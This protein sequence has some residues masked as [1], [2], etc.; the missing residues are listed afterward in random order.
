MV[1]VAIVEAKPSRNNYQEY[2]GFPFDQYQLCSNPSI[3]K[4][5]KRDVDI[6]IDTDEYDFVILVG[7]EPLK[8]FTKATSITDYSGSILEKK[9]LPVINPAMLTFKPEVRSLWESSVEKV[10]KYIEGD[11]EEFNPFHDG[12]I[13]IEEPEVAEAYLEMI[14]DLEPTYVGLDSET[15]GLYPRNGY[16]LGMSIS[17]IDD[18]G[19]YICLQNAYSEKLVELLQQVADKH[20][21][22]FHNSKFDIPFFSYHLG[23]KFPRYEDTM[24]LHYL[25]D[26]NPGTHGLKQ[27]AMRYTRY[28]DY[29]KTMYQ[30][31]ADYCKTHGLRRA[32][33]RWEFIPFDVMKGY[34]AVDAIVTRLL[35]A[36]FEKIKQNK[37]LRS[38]YENI[39]IP[40]NNFLMD[41]QDNGVPFCKERLIKSQQLMEKEIE[42]AIENLYKDPRIKEFEAIQEKPFNP[43]SVMQLRSLLFDHLGLNPTGKKTE[44]GEHSTDAEVLEALSS[45]SEVPGLILTIRKMS[46]I[47]NTYLDKII[48]SLDSDGRLRTNFN[49]HSTTSGRLS[50]SGKLNMQQIPRD[51]PVVKGC[52]RARPGWKIVAMDLTTAE[53]YLAAVLS[54]D[55]ELM[56]AFKSGQNLHSTIAHKVFN[57]PCEI[58]EV[59]DLYP[60]E[61]QAAKAITFG[62]MYGASAGKISQEVSKSTGQPFTKTEAQE[63]IDEY[64]K[65]FKGLKKWIDKNRDEIKRNGFVYSFFG[66]KRR[67]HNVNSDNSGEVGH[68]VRSGLNFLVQSPASDVNLLGAIELNQIIKKRQ[69]KSKIF[70]LV[71]DSILAEVPENEV[72]TYKEL[73]TECI[74]RDRGLSIPGCPI[75]VDIDVAD[76]YSLGKYAA[77]FE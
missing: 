49:L 10:Y 46:K 26:E 30:W 28:G 33:F 37:R 16:M 44:K 73:I 64:F 72:D 66:R 41:V 76:D 31:I 77:K 5:L 74:Q 13:G 20:T 4:V 45:Q 11:L 35:F 12:V 7:S 57:L 40:G 68:T 53:A 70:A 43:N 61:R 25:I 27:L 32:D 22:V 51:N 69:M 9:F 60:M 67:L 3:K 23:T 63:F 75:G 55:R 65:S 38:V 59:S 1:R 29:E 36:K 50:S 58:S 21:I 47:K 2:F 8:Y 24:L 18:H 62:I 17:A 54:Q 42:T 19:A 71:H 56:N 52:I 14:L 6:S 48:P 39:L 15:T 34:A